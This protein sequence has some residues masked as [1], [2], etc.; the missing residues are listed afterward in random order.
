MTGAPP[1]SEFKPEGREKLG[2]GGKRLF[3][4]KGSAAPPG[5]YA[6]SYIHHGDGAI[7]SLYC[8]LRSTGYTPEAAYYLVLDLN[9]V[10]K[11]SSNPTPG[12]VK[13]ANGH[14]YADLNKAPPGMW[15]RTSHYIQMKK[16]EEERIR[17]NAKFRT[18]LQYDADQGTII[19]DSY[20]GTT[21][22]T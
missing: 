6:H 2:D 12:L 14:W 22:D 13:K 7:L 10:H 4:T 15:G 19:E 21:G 11:N 20:S 18:D 16:E 5:I 1:A 3:S 17:R 8:Y 9:K